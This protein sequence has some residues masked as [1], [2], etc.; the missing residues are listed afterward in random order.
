MLMVELSDSTGIHTRSFRLPIF[1]DRPQNINSK[2]DL[3]QVNHH[4][5]NV[6]QKLP[7]RFWWVM[8]M[9]S[10][11]PSRLHTSVKEVSDSYAL[12]WLLD[13]D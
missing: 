3:A 8:Q 2:P 13:C 12:P 6:I 7:D 11:L 1:V 10:F 4:A 9:Q 5:L